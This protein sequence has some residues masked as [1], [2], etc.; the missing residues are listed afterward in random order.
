M[1]LVDVSNVFSYERVF[2]ILKRCL[3]QREQS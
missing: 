1:E 3:K 2:D